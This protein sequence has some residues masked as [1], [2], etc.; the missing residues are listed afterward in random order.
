MSTIRFINIT[1]LLHLGTVT[2]QVGGRHQLR[3][4]YGSETIVVSTDVFYRETDVPGSYL[5]YELFHLESCKN[6][7]SLPQGDR[8]TLPYHLLVEQR[9][10]AK[11]GDIKE[12]RQLLQLTLP[13]AAN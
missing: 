2:E 9:K 4:V 10:V 5:F 3:N 8:N 6:R 12:L 7:P 1:S 13:E 11:R